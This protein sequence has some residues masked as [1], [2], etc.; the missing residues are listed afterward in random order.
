M[1]KLFQVVVPKAGM[2]TTEVQ[3]VRWLARIGDSVVKGT[4]LVELETEKVTFT[5]ESEVAGELVETF[6]PQGSVVPVGQPLCL[7]QMR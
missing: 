1:C 2:D 4:A 6:H 3:I 5:L 7:V